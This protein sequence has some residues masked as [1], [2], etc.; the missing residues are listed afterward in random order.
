MNRGRRQRGSALLM[1]LMTLALGTLLLR[2]LGLH[3]RL[4]Q[5]ILALE[6]QRIQMS[7][8]AHSALAWGMRQT[9]VPTP[10]WQCREAP[11]QGRACLRATANDEGVLMGLD[12]TETMRY[13]Q[14][15]TITEERIRAQP[16]GWSD[17][18]PLADGGCELP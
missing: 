9:W 16:R 8:R 17:F 15:V 14:W 10:T 11:D 12:S 3:H 1:V 4:R 6:I 7:S 2:G 5:P 13:W 18:C